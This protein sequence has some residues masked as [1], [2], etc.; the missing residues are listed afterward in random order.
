[1]ARGTLVLLLLL[2]P[3]AAAGSGTWAEGLF[4][5]L[6]HDFGTVPRGPV[7]THT[8]TVTNNTA[9]PLHIAAVRSSCGCL[10]GTVTRTELAPG[11]SAAVVARVET[12]RFA[13]FWKKPLYVQFDQPQ[14]AE[15]ALM[16]SAT[17][18]EDMTLTPQALALGRVRRG[19]TAD[20]S[21]TVLLAGGAW[22]LVGAS[23]ESDYVQ[24]AVKALRH[25]GGEAAYQVTAR[26]LP[27]LPPGRWATTVWVTTD[28]PAVPRVSVPVTVEVE[29]ALTISPK[30]IALGKVKQGQETERKVLVRADQPFRIVSVK[31]TDGELTVE[32]GT[33]KAAAVHVLRVKLRSSRPGALMRNVEIATDLKD[34]SRAGFQATAEV[35]P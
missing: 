15:V 25:D 27:G 35:V 23:S 13:G 3:A 12:S 26:L 9:A 10:S 17:S 19:G 2:A 5:E 30:V 29:P 14:F 32:D 6:S 31:G 21:I 1:M 22:K 34:D 8:F 11:E 24:P 7:V 4:S 16:I 33:P 20:G 18:R 28:N